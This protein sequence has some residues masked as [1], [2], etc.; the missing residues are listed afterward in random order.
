[1]IETSEFRKGLKVEMDGAPWVV[2]D[3]QHVKPGKGNSFTRTRLKNMITGQVVDYTFK[4]GDTLGKPDVEEAEVQFLYAM[5]DQYHFMNSSTY[6][7][8]TVNKDSIEEAVPFLKEETTVSIVF[9]NGRAIGVNLPNFVELKIIE[10]E[11][12]VKG[13]TA[14]N[15]TKTAK[16]ETGYTLQVPLFVNQDEVIRI[17]TRNGQYSERVRK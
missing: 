8:L 6:E 15:A 5:D 7:Q 2:V 3:F 13:D 9:Y 11:P 14:T 16:V 12:G 4:S 1:M 17:D 10:C